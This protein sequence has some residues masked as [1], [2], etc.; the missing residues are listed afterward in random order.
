MDLKDPAVICRLA[1][2]LR[3]AQGRSL[4]LE[5]GGQSLR[6]ALSDTVATAAAP[7]KASHATIASTGFGTYRA[8]SPD[9][10]L[11]PP[12]IGETLKVGQWL[13]CL[14]AG[15]LILPIRA[16]ETGTLTEMQAAEGQLV[17]FSD[18][19]F[20]IATSHEIDG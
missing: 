8:T 16:A 17:E 1:E 14:V 13:G 4:S 6:I 10:L 5:L 3:Q 2:A 20:S 9:G 7:T 18:P 11:T 15:D 19:L 12:E